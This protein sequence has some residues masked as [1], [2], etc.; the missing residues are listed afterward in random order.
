MNVYAPIGVETSIES[1][2]KVWLTVPQDC[3]YRNTLTV[4]DM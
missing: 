3:I 4:A 2:N 1:M